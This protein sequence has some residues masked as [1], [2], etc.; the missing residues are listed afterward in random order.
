MI[1]TGIVSYESDIWSLAIMMLKILLPDFDLSFL[2][3]EA[4]KLLLKDNKSIDSSI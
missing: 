1:L 2:K 4:I 3:I